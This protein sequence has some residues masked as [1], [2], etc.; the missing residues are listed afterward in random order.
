MNKLRYRDMQYE[1]L[2]TDLSG[3]DILW[4]IVFSTENEQVFSEAMHFL[5]S[6]HFMVCALSED[7]L[8]HR[9]IPL[10]FLIYSFFFH[11]TSL[12]LTLTSQMMRRSRSW[13]TF[14]R[15]CVFN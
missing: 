15:R 13:K 11:R 5:V 2:R 12:V 8:K 14:A 10:V 4:D 7:T 1:I 3:F 9:R 6:L